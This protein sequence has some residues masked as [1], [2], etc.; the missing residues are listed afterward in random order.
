MEAYTILRYVSLMEVT[1]YSLTQSILTV[2]LYL[3]DSMMMTF[4]MMATILH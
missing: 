1:A 4:F 3:L 2:N